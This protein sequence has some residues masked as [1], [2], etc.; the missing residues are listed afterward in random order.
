MLL[1]ESN[2]QLETQN[3]V[4]AITGCLW[5]AL[6]IKDQADLPTPFPSSVETGA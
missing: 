6:V 2:D 4:S 1:R 3:L 5:A